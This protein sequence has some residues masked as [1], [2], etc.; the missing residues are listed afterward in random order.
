M[1]RPQ[2]LLY[3]SLELLNLLR[4]YRVQEFVKRKITISSYF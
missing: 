2:P 1:K 3:L 4:M